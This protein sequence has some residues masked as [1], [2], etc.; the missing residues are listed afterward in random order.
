VHGGGA[1]HPAGAGRKCSLAAART[2]PI[3]G[4]RPD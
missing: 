4:G 1:F 2:Q 3:Q